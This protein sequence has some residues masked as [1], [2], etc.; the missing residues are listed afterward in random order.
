VWF[1]KAQ[2]HSKLNPWV[3]FPLV[4]ILLSCFISS[5]STR[6]KQQPLQFSVTT[7]VATAVP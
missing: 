5:G 2:W 7:A 4:L 1:I 6:G 3:S